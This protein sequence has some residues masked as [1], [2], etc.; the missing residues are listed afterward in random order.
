MTNDDE[1]L[2]GVAPRPSRPWRW[3]AARWAVAVFVVE[4]LI[5]TRLSHWR[6]VRASLGDYLVVFVLYFGVLT[7]RDVT[8]RRLAVAVFAFAA[9]VEAG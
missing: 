9:A 2:A 5:A 4:V 8:P 6:W 7:L 3:R 1:A